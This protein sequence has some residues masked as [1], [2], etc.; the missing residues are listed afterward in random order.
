MTGSAVCGDVAAGLTMIT[1]NNQPVLLS[2]K[3]KWGILILSF[4]AQF[5]TKGSQNESTDNN[6]CIQ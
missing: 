6:S 1:N 5:Y 2:Y 4:V 3:I